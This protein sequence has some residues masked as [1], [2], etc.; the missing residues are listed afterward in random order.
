MSG[1][2]PRRSYAALVPRLER[3]VLLAP[4]WVARRVA[5]LAGDA[6][7][8][9]MLAQPQPVRADYVRRVLDAGGSERVQTIWMLRQ[10]GPVRESYIREVLE[11]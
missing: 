3:S 10:A 5:A 2:A 11:A 4:D 6:E 7:Q 1:P 9:W 8:R